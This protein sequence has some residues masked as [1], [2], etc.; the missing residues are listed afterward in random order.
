MET[1]E[2]IEGLRLVGGD[3]ALDFANTADGSLEGDVGFDHLG[4]YRD[5]VAWAVR[6][7]V[8]DE[9]AAESF[10]ARAERRPEEGGA[11]LAQALELRSEIY[12][13]FEAIALG[14]QPSPE[15][16][17]TLR[18]IYGEAA[19]AG[20]LVPQEEAFGWDWSHR[21]E[22]VALLWPVAHHA[23]T[24]LTSP[25]LARVKRCRACRWLFVDSTKNSSRRWC[26]MEECGTHEKMRRYVE[27]RRARRS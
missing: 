24:L 8:I 22:C 4:G 13:V 18:R 25:K 17:A 15:S 19:A 1:I 9:R 16:L 14:R 5:L 10:L 26:H 21:E 20:A 12:S 11:V 7:C 23:M 27:R 6:A 2:H 3:P